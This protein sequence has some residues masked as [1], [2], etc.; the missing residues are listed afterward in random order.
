MR[1]WVDCGTGSNGSRMARVLWDSMGLPSF[2]YKY[3]K[4]RGLPAL[5]KGLML[6]SIRIIR[7]QCAWVR[8]SVCRNPNPLGNS[9]PYTAK[10]SCPPARQ[11]PPLPL[12]P[13]QQLKR[14]LLIANCTRLHPK[15][16]FLMG[17][18]DFREW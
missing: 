15:G 9:I 12:P 7:Y 5:R 17:V 13:Q 3:F 14:H 10:I 6:V 8:H 4:I 2:E 16:S 11:P 18:A 1:S